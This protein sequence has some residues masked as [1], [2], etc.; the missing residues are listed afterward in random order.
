MTVPMGSRARRTTVFSG[1]VMGLWTEPQ[2]ASIHKMLNPGSIAIVGA[3]PR[4]Q[5]GGRFL[6]AALKG[7]DRIRV[8]AVNPR[9][10]E[11]MGVKSYPSVTDLPEAPDLVAI[12]VP[13]DQVLD[14]LHESHRKGA[15]SAIVIS[16]GFAERGVD[17][18]RDLQRELGEFARDTGLRI[19]GPNCL[20]LANL[21]DDIWATASSRGAEGLTGP[22]GLVCQSGATAFGP[23]LVRAVENGIGFSYIISTGNEADLD[24]TDFA[25]YLL[26]DPDTRVIAGFVEGFK[27]ADKFLEL[28]KLAAERGKPIV[29]IKIG[30]SELGARAARSHTAALT[31]AD[32]RYD[33]VFA[34][35]GVI[36]VQDYDELIEVAHLM[37]H[38]PKPQVPGI[39]VVSH[40]GGISSLT[41]DMCGQAGLDLPPLGDPARDGI[42]GILKG[43][44][45]AANPADVTGFANSESFPQI[46]EHM[47]ND[48]RMGT[49]VVAS[50]GADTQA[51]QVISQRDR[52]DKGVVFL[53][54]GSRDAKAGLPR[55]KEA[56]I[57]IFYTPDKLARGL[58]SRLAYHTWRERRL[59]DGFAAAPPRTPAQ[60]AAIAR[61]LGL[62]RPTLSES[63]SKQLLAAWGV[64]SARERLVASAEEA[65]A[66]AEQLGFPVALKVDS[67]DILHKTEAGIIRLNLGDAAQVRTAYAE[68]LANAMAYL[69]ALPLE[70]GGLG[71]GDAC[72]VLASPPPRPSPLKGEGVCTATATS[73]QARIAGISVQEMVRDG[74]EVIIGVSSDPQLGPVLLFGTGGVMVEV[75]ND[76][77]LRRCP[78]T[79]AEAEAMIAAVKGA[80]LLQGFRGRPPAD[81][82]ALADTL[83][84]VSYLAM[85]LEDH[86]AELDI[87]PLM[88]LP[89]GQGVKAVD[90]LV[91][92][93]GE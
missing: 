25:R 9:Y 90:A 62:G 13:W 73:P 89:S 74:V 87:N 88:V 5:Y 38:T 15:G 40:S 64:A 83:V 8:Y 52:T 43:F 11:I 3:T 72:A 68:I 59:A 33:A 53:W 14:V 70:G 7:K 10:D 29:L 1:V 92:L 41:A 93:R 37:A 84:R 79:R 54:T 51:N 78:I 66:A 42:N 49:L 56:R 71:G 75:Y 22:I 77:A 16:A 34:Q 26:D 67:P 17:D 46:M 31:G 63:E 44:G 55:L 36:R 86:L 76:V 30:R 2:M 58:Q 19:S 28:A 24:F 21:K 50:A 80:R 65:V 23:F 81:L 47:V 60:D 18:R 61:A 85:H 39:A 45:W 32:A 48:P 4:M 35:Y 82:D 69:P 20:G 6:A 91:V 27:R 12:V 57:P